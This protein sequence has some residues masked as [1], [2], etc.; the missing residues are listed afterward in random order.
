MKKTT[1]ALL[2]MGFAGLATAQS[3]VTLYGVADM[4][5]VKNTGQTTQ[6]LSSGT[7]NNATSRWGLRGTEDLGGGLK[8]GFNF[9][10]QL[11][12]TDGA[13]AAATFARAANMTLSGDFGSVKAGRTTTPSWQGTMAWELTSSA[14][15]AV[16][17]S[18][19]GYGGLNAR[20]NAEVSYTSPSFNGL[21]M[22]VGHLF[23][24]N[25]GNVAKNDVNVIYR[26]GPLAAALVYNKL[27]GKGKNMSLGGAYDFGSF[28]LAGSWQDAT[29]AG[30][31]K[32][33]TLGGTVPFGNLAITVD[34]A[35]D[36]QKKDTDTLLEAKY[37]LTKR[38]SVY[39]VLLHNGAGKAAKS[40]NATVVGLRHNF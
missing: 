17:N 18:Q 31:G 8:A 15:Y 32:G 39:G 4:A 11:S 37:A 38:T 34:V 20:H 35:R 25:N 29:G 1:L 10:S 30:L 28:K 26:A 2:A 36:T 7:Q 13:T 21:S 12:L 22:T 40:V 19:F 24:A 16:V 23:A 9:E 27:D 3:S 5:L 33:Y 14:N 6:L